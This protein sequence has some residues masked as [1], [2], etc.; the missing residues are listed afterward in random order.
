MRKSND[1]I[2][3]FTH[4]TERDIDVLLVEELKA[5]EDFL[6]WVLHKVGWEK[7]I[8]SYNVLHS[9]RRTRNRRE[10]DIYIELFMADIEQPTVVL[11]ENK[12]D[13]N[14]QPDQAESYREELEE[15]AENTFDSFMLLVCPANYHEQHSTFANKFDA[16]VHYEEIAAFHEARLKNTAG[17]LYRRLEFRKQ[18]FEQAIHKYRRGYTPIP[19]PVIGE[20]NALYVDLLIKNAPEIYPGAAMVKSS[21]PDESVSMIFDHVKTFAKIIEGGIPIRRFAHEFGKNQSHRANYVAVAFAGWGKY[22]QEM[23]TTLN[24]DTK[25]YGFSFSSKKP[26]KSRPNPA[27]IMA[28]ETC[29]INNQADFASQLPHLEM[30]LRTAQRHRSWLFNNIELLHKWKNYIR[31]LEA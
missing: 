14:E 1:F 10:I 15:I 27:L 23:Q 3:T 8:V 6:N 7:P 24:N 30:G 21:N 17:E 9:K 20:F 26:N 11:I 13:A 19:N 12:L 2:P 25:D 31:Q 22:L 28:L 16:V 18:L 29:P 5:S 4:A